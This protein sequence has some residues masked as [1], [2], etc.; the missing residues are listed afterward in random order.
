M[1]TARSTRISRD[2][3]PAR[4]AHHRRR[5]RAVSADLQAWPE[6]Q[7]Q[8]QADLGRGRET[9]ASAGPETRTRRR[10]AGSTVLAVY[11]KA[12]ESISGGSNVPDI[13][14]FFCHWEHWYD[15]RTR[16]SLDLW[17]DNLLKPNEVGMQELGGFREGSEEHGRVFAGTPPAKSRR[18]DGP[19]DV[20][21]W[22]WSYPSSEA[23]SPTPRSGPPA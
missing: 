20:I 16:S 22:R 5:D 23:T 2:R 11:D 21:G 7:G 9:R 6:G 1:R 10:F 4:V 8:A 15:S 14:E 13:K 3:R 12:V 17:F 18:T 19:P